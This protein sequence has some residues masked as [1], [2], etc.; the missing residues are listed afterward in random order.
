ML[1]T[2]ALALITTSVT[3]TAITPPR[4][5]AALAPVE[6]FAEGFAR[7]RGI[8]VDAD[9]AVYV[10]DRESGTVTRLSSEGRRVVA[11][12]LER[13]VGL[14]FDHD[15]RVLVAE[16]R[17]GRVVR[18][19][20]NGPTPLARGI[21]QP[22]WLAVNED[23]TV[24]IS[25]RRLT[26]DTD[27]EPDDETLEP[28]VILA[29]SPDGAL[30]V[31][32]D[33]FDH[34]QGLVVHGEAVYAAS[35]GP[36]GVPRQ[37]G[38]VY[39]IP[40][41]PGGQAGKIAR[42]GPRDVFERP[43]GLAI[44]RVG[45]LYASAASTILDGPRSS[46]AIVKIRPDGAASTFAT[47]LEDP[48]G[49]AFDSLGH[50][51]VADGNAGRVLRFLAP[52]PPTM[53]AV[54]PFTRL[55]TIGLSGFTSP[56]ARVDALIEDGG[57]SITTI[58][59]ATGAFQLSLTPRPN[60]SNR[61]EIMATG[62]RGRGLASPPSEVAFVH[63]TIAPALVLLTP[64]A[65]GFARGTVEVRADAAD[66]GSQIATLSLG[67][68]GATVTPAL[69][70]VAASA[71]ASWR[72]TESVDGAHTLTATATD[73]AGNVAS[74]S[75]VAIVD[76]APPETERRGGPTEPISPTTATFSF[77]GT[78]NLTPSASVQFAWR[79]D[80]GAFGAFAP[81]ASVTLS[82][83]AP[84]PHVVEVVARDLAGNVDPT[85]ARWEFSVLDAPGVTVT[86]TSPASGAS[87]PS[88]GLIVR[89]TVQTT[90]A[91]TNVSVNGFAAL[92]H[93]PEWAVQVPMA[94]GETVITAI[95][96][97]ASGAESRASITVVP[98]GPAPVVTLR[99]EP[100]SGVAPLTVGWRLTSRASRPLV[101]FE[102]DENG[103]GAFGAAMTTL[104]GVE[105]L[106]TSP[107]LRFPKVRA[108]D[109]LGAVY[110]VTTLVQVD[111]AITA[112]ARFQNLWGGF[113]AR[114]QAGDQAGALAHLGP[115]LRS[116][117]EPILQQLGPAL[118]AIAAGFGPIELIDQVED[119]AETA[120]LQSEDG[121]TRLYFV[122]FRRDNRGQ[123]LIQ[124]M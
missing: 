16:E 56:H 106:Y 10:S 93:G 68:A 105:S 110:V 13:P 115:A 37:G 121:V 75:R 3:G 1:R 4:P 40:I 8:A 46:Q 11:R 89:G 19:D 113:K 35:T 22:R 2:L 91:E 92:V 77:N 42:L 62:M 60:L 71:A 95:A 58:A 27:P 7:L 26:R 116:R 30:S 70:A 52:P 63:D 43:V 84:G 53:A 38:V 47:G 74:V 111:D 80:G 101:R 104:D 12:R 34:L 103:T 23:G 20:P 14:A 6:I 66:T 118:P 69:P 108:T 36:R 51:Y 28:E 18:L 21:K 99:A 94:P 78:D 5:I 82:Q 32:A 41:L 109:D 50:L 73:R 117:F 86:I 76:N 65:G 33:G 48:R 31:F 29:L 119:L 59:S 17:A 55:V 79:L 90:G 25:A 15:G 97:T 120:M 107:G 87:V 61:V 124:E 64:P 123:W 85:P 39:R 49:L 9:D 96:R 24:Y 67:V 72:T 57:A 83:L 54:A 98:T 44:D 45:V 88:E 81:D 112:T 100:G 114:L 122:Y 102:L